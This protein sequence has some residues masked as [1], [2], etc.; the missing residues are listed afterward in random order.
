MEKHQD[1]EVKK[2]HAS[3]G[4]IDLNSAKKTVQKGSP[5]VGFTKTQRFKTPSNYDLD[6]SQGS[7][8]STSTVDSNVSLSAVKT[9]SP[10]VLFGKSKR[11]EQPKT[12]TNREFDLNPNYSAVKKR[13]PAAM[14]KTPIKNQLKVEFLQKQVQANAKAKA[15]SP[16]KG[17]HQN[18]ESMETVRLENMERGSCSMSDLLSDTTE[19][20]GP[21]AYNVDYR[22][23]EVRKS[24]GFTKSLRFRAD[25]KDEQSILNPKYQQIHKAVPG[26]KIAAET[27]KNEKLLKKKSEE[28]FYQELSN[29]LRQN[30]PIEIDKGVRKNVPQVFIKQELESLNETER[31]KQIFHMVKIIFY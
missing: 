16:Q 20:M 31:L 21:G 15:A 23:V 11:F 29:Q 14:I 1:P 12:E 25:N 17:E 24:V 4:M 19:I 5:H 7:I 10:L 6:S 30:A 22:G 9:R 3:T 2:R 18:D 27:Q 13:E 28:K 8:D 26:V